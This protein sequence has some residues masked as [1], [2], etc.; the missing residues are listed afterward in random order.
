MRGLLTFIAIAGIGAGLRDDKYLVGF[1]GF[2]LAAWRK[3]AHADVAAVGV[4]GLKTKPGF[5]GTGLAAGNCA[6][7]TD[8]EGLGDGL[9][10]A[11]RGVARADPATGC[12]GLV[13][14]DVLRAGVDSVR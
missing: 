11:T 10:A 8:G 2:H 12:P 9:F 14:S 13:T 5:P 1:R 4:N 7:L 6:A 3:A